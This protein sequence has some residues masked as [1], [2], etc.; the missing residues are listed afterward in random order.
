M[1]EILDMAKSKKS[2]N[3]GFYIDEFGE[4]SDD[5]ICAELLDEPV[6]SFPSWN[7]REAKR[8]EMRN[9]NNKKR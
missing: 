6:E 8:K 5:W 9:K 3:E 1:S 2:S 4:K 7:R